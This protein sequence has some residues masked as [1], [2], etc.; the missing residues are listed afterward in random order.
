MPQLQTVVIALAETS[1]NVTAW[2]EVGVA[3]YIPQT[4]GLREVGPILLGVLAGERVYSRSVAA[5]LFRRLTQ[6]RANSGVPQADTP[7]SVLTTREIQIVDLISVGMSNKQIARQ[8]NI[9]V[10]TTKSHV[11]NLLGKLDLQRRGQVV[12]RLGAHRATGSRHNQVA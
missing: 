10:S 2:A 11:H 8:L 6:L 9:G 7:K 4:A 1:D 3:G 5:G 12:F